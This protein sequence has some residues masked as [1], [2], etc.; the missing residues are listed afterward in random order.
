MSPPLR[1][2]KDIAALWGAIDQ[3]TVQVVATDHCPFTME[4][5]AMGKDDFSKI[6]NGHPAI[7]HRM[8][9]LFSEGVNKKRIT[10]N[11]FVEVTATN[12]AKIFGMFP[13]KGTIGIGS[14]ADIILLDP[15]E[16]HTLSAKTHHMNTDYSGYEGMELTGKV[17]TTILRG[18]LA[19]HN[20]EVKIKKGYG[21]FVKRNK[22]SGML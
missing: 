7:E 12:P 9:L 18:Q 3:G 8:E 16:K 22:V 13:R 11:K 14:D 5:K 4:Q 6:P 15:N 20:G 1:E 2:K 17:K 19:V 21:T 10:L